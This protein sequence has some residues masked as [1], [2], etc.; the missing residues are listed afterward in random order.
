MTNIFALQRRRPYPILLAGADSASYRPDGSQGPRLKKIFDNERYIVLC[1][2]SYNVGKAINERLMGNRFYNTFGLAKSLMLLGESLPRQDLVAIDSM[3]LEMI[4]CGPGE[5]SFD[6]YLLDFTGHSGN[7]KENQPRLFKKEKIA[8]A[9]SACIKTGNYAA[10]IEKSFEDEKIFQ[11]AVKLDRL[12]EETG[13]CSYIDQFYMY[14]MD[15]GDAADKK[16]MLA[17]MKRAMPVSLRYL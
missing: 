6:I 5:S 4:V 12:G 15:P 9:G 16:K 7:H 8:V 1:A 2:G 17:S 14:T 13:K 10:Q 11:Y 3:G